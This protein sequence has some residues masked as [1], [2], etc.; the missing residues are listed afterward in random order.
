MSIQSEIDRLNIV[1]NGINEAI[2]EKGGTV[3]QDAK[4][5]DMPAGIRSIP[6]GTT[7]HN[8]LTN[9]NIADQHSI[10]AI[11][12][13]QNTLDG[14]ASKPISKS[15]SIAVADWTASGEQFTAT[16]TVNDITDTD[17]IIITADPDSFSAWAESTIYCSAQANQSLTFTAEQKPDA[18]V[19]MNL[20][21]LR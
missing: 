18:P 15:V 11:T 10:S 4:L 17:N 9:R 3:A 21:I 6:Q 20:L 16:K 13:L 2:T 14:K 5:N 7:D 12:D 8:E 1:K 19:T